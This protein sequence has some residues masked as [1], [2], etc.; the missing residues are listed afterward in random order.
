MRLPLI[1]R[2]RSPGCRPAR[3]AGLSGTTSRTHPY[4]FGINL[5]SF[6]EWVTNDKSDDN[7]QDYKSEC[8][9]YKIR[10]FTPKFDIGARPFSNYC[11]FHILLL[12]FAFINA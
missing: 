6:L 11:L 9:K 12:L 10:V 1:V 8:T 4:I 3:S 2:I 7:N 5:V